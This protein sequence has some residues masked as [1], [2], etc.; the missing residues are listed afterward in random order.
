MGHFKSVVIR[1]SHVNTSPFIVDDIKFSKV[2]AVLIYELS[3]H[4]RSLSKSEYKFCQ[5][6]LYT[7]LGEFKLFMANIMT[8]VRAK[9]QLLQLT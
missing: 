5:D 9:E 8:Q 7:D 2:I 3:C 6:F 4:T 1:F